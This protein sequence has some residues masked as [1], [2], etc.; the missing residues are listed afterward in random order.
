MDQLLADLRAAKTK[1]KASLDQ[2]Y[3]DKEEENAAEKRVQDHIQKT[4]R[5]EYKDLFSDVRVIFYPRQ[6]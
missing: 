2:A 4:L 3:K 1:A 5:E 6:S